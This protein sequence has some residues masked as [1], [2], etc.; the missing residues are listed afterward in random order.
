MDFNRI[1][2]SLLHHIPS[3]S[4]PGEK[5]ILLGHV[6]GLQGQCHTSLVNS[7]AS[8]SS[9][10]EGVCALPT[11]QPGHVSFGSNMG[12]KQGSLAISFSLGTSPPGV[13]SNVRLAFLCVAKHILPGSSALGLGSKGQLTIRYYQGILIRVL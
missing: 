8:H 2:S 12:T 6:F 5:E 1:N 13:G 9:E 4:A 10:L 3:P 7:L 11:L